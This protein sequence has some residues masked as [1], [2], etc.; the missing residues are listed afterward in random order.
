[1]KG[2]S[3]WRRDRQCIHKMGLTKTIDVET[4]LRELATL[5]IS[6]FIV[7][8]RDVHTLLPVAQVLSWQSVALTSLPGHMGVSHLAELTEY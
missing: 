3:Q 7:S 6:H 2:C 8:S 1:M 5:A 4:I